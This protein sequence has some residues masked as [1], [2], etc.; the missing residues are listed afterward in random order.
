MIN[1]EIVQIWEKLRTRVLEAAAPK[2]YPL[3][4]PLTSTSW[5]GDSFSTTAKTKID[6]SAVFGAPAGVKAVLIWVGIR[7]SGSAGGDTYLVL[8]PTNSAGVGVSVGPS[9]RANDA[10][11]RAQLVV[12]CDANGD[13]YYQVAASGAS[14][15]DIF[16]QIDGYW[17]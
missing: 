9:G 7:D 1:E 8:G 10:W 13:I 11:E 3:A 12:P 2:F 4:A 5:D 16:L 17:L 15:M 6:L 14:T